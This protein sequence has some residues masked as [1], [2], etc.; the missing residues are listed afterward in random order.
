MHKEWKFYLLS[1][2]WKKGGGEG[3]GGEEKCK[4]KGRRKKI[5]FIME[6]LVKKNNVI[7]NRER[8][9]DDSLGSVGARMQ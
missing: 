8:K 7:D 1:I 3:G 6:A 4:I 2:E 9:R 5:A